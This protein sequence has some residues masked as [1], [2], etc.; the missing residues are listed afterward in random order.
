[1]ILASRKTKITLVP[2]GDPIMH[3]RCFVIEI[4]DDDDGGGEF[5]HVES[6]MGETGVDFEATEWDALRDA[7]DEMVKEIRE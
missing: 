3:E 1:V 5:I 4:R 6:N 2:P 7:I